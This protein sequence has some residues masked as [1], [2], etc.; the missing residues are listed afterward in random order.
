MDDILAKH[1]AKTLLFR[2]NKDSINSNTDKKETNINC[3]YYNYK[4]I[5]NKYYINTGA[6]LLISEKIGIWKNKDIVKVNEEKFVVMESTNT[7]IPLRHVSNDDFDKN[8]ISSSK[9]PKKKN[10]S[11]EFISSPDQKILPISK[12]EDI[13]NNISTK[14]QITQKS[15]DS[16]TQKYINDIKKSTNSDFS[17]KFEED[18]EENEESNSFFDML[19][20]KKD[21]PRVKKFFNYH[22][23]AMKKEFNQIIEKVKSSQ[24]ARAME[25]GGGTNA[26]QYANGGIMNG[27]LNV[28]NQIISENITDTAGRELVHK[29][30]FD[31]I[32]NGSNNTFTLNHNFNTK[33][34]LIN[35][36]DSVNYQLI[37][38][39][40]INVDLNNTMINFPNDLKVNENYRVILFA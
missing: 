15:E 7:I 11:K 29:K 26:V 8:F 18:A 33:D 14:P 36:Y 24:M 3:G 35:V 27:T 5:D 12:K 20:K 28:T 39:S 13:S 30:K 23:D 40:S 2:E 16:S 9:I 22:A 21:D 25:S 17:K 6:D 19:E 10:T 37:F 1:L 34:I 4:L 31:I 32:G 38:V